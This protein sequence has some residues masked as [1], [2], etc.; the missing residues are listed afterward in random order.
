MSLNDFNLSGCELMTST[1]STPVN[2]SR[3]D[4]LS[5]LSST[6][7]GQVRTDSHVFYF[8]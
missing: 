5:S 1:V 4:T 8:L 2:S 6:P 7:V 3:N